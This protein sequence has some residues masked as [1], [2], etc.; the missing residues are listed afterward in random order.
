MS[1]LTWNSPVTISGPT[2]SDPRVVIDSSGNSTAVWVEQSIYNTGTA[3]QSGTTIT[4]TGTTFTSSMVGGTITYSNGIMAHITAFVNATSLTTTESLTVS[5]QAYTIYY[6]GVVKASILPNGGSWG[7]PIQLSTSGNNSI[8]PKIGIDSNAIVSVVWAENTIINYASYNGVWSSVT[9]LS[10]GTGSS[11]P[12]IGVDTNGNVVVAWTKSAK[13]E[14]IVKPISTGIWSSVTTFTTT[15]SDNPSIAIGGG[16]TTVVWHAKPS[17]QDQIIASTATTIGGAF[18]TPV[19]IIAVTGTGHMANY[20]KIV[21]DAFGNSIAVWYR[22]DLSGLNNTEYIN[23]IVLGSTLVSG[24][25]SWS[26]PVMLSS[27]TGMRNPADLVL[28]SAVDP[29]GNAIILLTSSNTGN[30][31]NIEANIRQNSGNLSGATTIINSNLTVYDTSISINQLSGVLVLYMYYDGINSVIQAIETDIGGYPLNFYTSP[32][33]ISTSGT[34]NAHPKGAISV[35]GS[36]VSAVAVWQ[37]Y[38]SINNTTIIQAATGLKNLLGA[39]SNLIITQSSNN[40]GVFNEFDNILNWTDSTDP[41]VIGYNIYRNNIF[42]TQTI[43][44]FDTFIDNNRAESGTGVT[45]TYSIASFDSN[46]QQS[47]RLTSSIS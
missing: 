1:V 3:S 11:N 27:S 19:N 45:V 36:T 42:I 24:T 38:D 31:F 43:F 26:I 20:P 25:A 10:T 5:N 8:T 16:V 39:P 47:Q 44:G 13:T 29:V 6:N 18:S 37:S 4:G 23:V 9:A 35:T 33:T 15:N 34:N 7:S 46:Y 40:F 2:S 17:T 14:T 22:S 21:V 41:N 30:T 28:K 32:N 12:T